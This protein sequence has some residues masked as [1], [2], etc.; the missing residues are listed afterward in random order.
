MNV[1]NSDENERR[2]APG[3]KFILQENVSFHPQMN[4]KIYET[5]M[6]REKQKIRRK[7]LRKAGIWKR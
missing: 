6:G 1:N 4:C 7:S 3:G 5:G 2:F